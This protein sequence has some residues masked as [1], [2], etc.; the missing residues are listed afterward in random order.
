MDIQCVITNSID[1]Q[2]GS[3]HILGDLFRS[4]IIFIAADHFNDDHAS[5]L[6]GNTSPDFIYRDQKCHR[7][8]A[9][10]RMP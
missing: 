1:R 3:A 9:T 6:Y 2:I 4:V 10:D 7:P 5:L 8:L